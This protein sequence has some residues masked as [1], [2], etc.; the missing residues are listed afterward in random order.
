MS[1][2]KELIPMLPGELL[3]FEREQAGLSLERV[4][5]IARIRPSIL[6]AIESGQTEDM[7]SVYLRGYLRSYARALGIDPADVEEQIAQ[8]KGADP[9]VQSIFDGTSNRSRA[10]KWLKA[11]SY[12]AA[13]A[14]IAALVWQFTHE[15]VRFSQGDPQ[16]SGAAVTP[17]GA[18]ESS[19]EAGQQPSRAA[20]TH[21]NASIASVE[22]M[23]RGGSGSESQSVAEEAW[24]ALAGTAETS[25]SDLNTHALTVRTSADSW[26]EI[27]DGQGVQLELDLIRA[28]HERTY[29]GSGPF[30]V[31]FGRASAVELT[32]DGQPVDL[33]PFTHD[34][35]ARLTLADRQAAVEQPA[36]DPGNR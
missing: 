35:V 13:S 15:A 24:S 4:A 34:N 36:A 3:R 1:R 5:A 23:Q 17:A 27:V 11:S 28:G 25:E 9:R 12:L 7:P 2:Q 18:A 16:L 6:E 22:V 31:M 21:L 26:V 32:L 20:N 33:A 8:V 19:R 10:E 14:V 29:S 30:E